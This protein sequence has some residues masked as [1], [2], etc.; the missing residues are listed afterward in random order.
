MPMRQTTGLNSRLT[1]HTNVSG[2]PLP[3]AFGKVNF[4]R[5]DEVNNRHL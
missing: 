5:Q 2:Y 1:L 4:V 3:S